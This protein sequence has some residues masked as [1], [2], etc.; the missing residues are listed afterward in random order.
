MGF[1][2]S[3]GDVFVN[4]RA[5]LDKYK[6]D[7]RM[8]EN[9]TKKSANKMQ[10]TLSNF[11]GDAKLQ[12]G[13]AAAS[14]GFF[15]KSMLTAASDAEESRQKFDVVFGSMSD[16]VAEWAKVQSKAIG[17]SRFAFIDYLATL[18][19]TFVPMG[20]ARDKAAELSKKMVLLAEDVGAFNNKA[21]PDV[22]RDFQSAL[23]G[24][25]ETLRKYG[26]AINQSILEQ[27][28]LN[29][30][31]T[32]GV[33]NA[34][35]QLK[36]Q[37]RLNLIMKG[38][39]DAMGAAA[40]EAGSYSNKLKAAEAALEELTV[41]V[42]SEF[43]PVATDMLSVF[44]SMPSIVQAA[45][46]AIAAL[47]ASFV[48]LGGPITAAVAGVGLLAT[49]LANLPKKSLPYQKALDDLADKTNSVVDTTKGAVGEVDEFAAANEA[50]AKATAKA[51]A[52]QE[53]YN[54]AVEASRFGRGND[55]HSELQAQAE[56]D[57]KELNRIRSQALSGTLETTVNNKNVEPKEEAKEFTE[58]MRAGVQDIFKQSGR[59]LLEGD[60]KG[61]L[62]SL[63][64][65]FA[66]KLQDKLLDRASGGL[67]DILV[68]GQGGGSASGGGLLGNMAGSLFGGFFADGG[69]PPTG[70]MSMVGERGPEMFVPKSKGTIIPNHALGGG[71]GSVTMHN[72]FNGDAVSKQEL[73]MWS[74][75]LKS[76]II[77]TTGRRA[78]NGG[79]FG[80]QF[81]N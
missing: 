6:K 17:R 42:G 22:I 68:G 32:E 30:G 49:G 59:F 51:A 56:E 25:V 66:S 26:V 7:M 29:M 18:Q 63:A 67:V 14:V 70:K 47:A 64:E 34:S 13:V 55:D 33:T 44:T 61:A 80:R 36:M 4:V 74:A 45:T 39:S 71:G 58:E 28:L 1:Q 73:A 62:Q 75:Q 50:I 5:K 31:F 40:R 43:L 57:A 60:F 12:M 79:A 21:T 78:T 27:E 69:V 10:R 8:A 3:L 37:A 38:T 16:D 52:S 53:R 76:N 41:S 19:D 65:S 2:D 81:G 23:V 35:E 11:A 72:T 48:V 77:E 46:V 24:N 9:T 54:A 20:M 15:A